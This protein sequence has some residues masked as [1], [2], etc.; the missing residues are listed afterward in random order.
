MGCISKKSGLWCRS[1]VLVSEA[2]IDIKIL[3][4]VASLENRTTFWLKPSKTCMTYHILKRWIF[5]NNDINRSIQIRR[6]LLKK[7]QNR[8]AFWSVVVDQGMMESSWISE[9]ITIYRKFGPFLGFHPKKNAGKGKCAN[10]VFPSLCRNTYIIVVG[11]GTLQ[12][13]TQA[14]AIIIFFYNSAGEHLF[15]FPK[16]HTSSGRTQGW[17]KKR[18]PFLRYHLTEGA[19]RFANGSEV[20]VRSI[21][22]WVAG[23]RCLQANTNS[24]I[25]R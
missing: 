7:S 16:I 19:V 23:S 14:F 12:L 25:W 13:A 8:R 4:Q 24:L 6:M 3:I 9:K 1:G 10:K 22:T 20:M 2:L 21:H 17:K 18:L 15:C 11:G 5:S